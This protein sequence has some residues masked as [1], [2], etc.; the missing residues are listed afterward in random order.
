MSLSDPFLFG[1]PQFKKPSGDYAPGTIISSVRSPHSSTHSSRAYG[2]TARRPH[3]PW[4][5]QGDDAFVGRRTDFRGPPTRTLTTTTRRRRGSN[6]RICVDKRTGQHRPC[7][8]IRG[9][10]RRCKGKCK[11]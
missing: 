1:F 9:R 7:D 8:E 2:I 5:A 4:N 3:D 6:P 10:K 11:H